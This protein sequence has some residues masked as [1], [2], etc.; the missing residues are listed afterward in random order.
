MMPFWIRGRS[1]H[2]E[3]ME[4]DFRAAES[5]VVF[6]Y[7]VPGFPAHLNSVDSFDF[8]CKDSRSLRVTLE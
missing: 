3:A 6:I 7:K 5:S 2:G 1:I 8:N 4:S